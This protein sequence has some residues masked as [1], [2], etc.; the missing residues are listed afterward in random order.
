MKYRCGLKTFKT[1]AEAEAYFNM[2]FK[3]SGI[4]LGIEEIK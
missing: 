1:F 4:I 2:M 3:I